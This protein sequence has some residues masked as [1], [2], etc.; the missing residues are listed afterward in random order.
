MQSSHNAKI[1]L[2]IPHLGGGGAERVIEILACNLSAQK[3]ELHLGLVTQ[4]Q[5][6][7]KNLPFSLTIHPLGA[8]RVRAGAIPLLKLVRQLKPDLILSGIF[9]L[10]FLVLLLRPLFPQQTRILIR[11]N[12]TVSAA[13]AFGGLPSTTRILYQLLYRCADRIICQTQAMADDL[14]A[15]L[16]LA[17]NR[18]AVLP[19]PVNVEEIR[20]AARRN[21]VLWTGPGP[22]L[23]AIGR[24]SPEKGFDLLLSAFSIIHEQY[25]SADLVIAGSGPQESALKVQS[26]ALALDAAVYFTG[27]IPDPVSY[28]PGATLFVLSSRH[29]GLPNALLE[30][31]AGELPIVALPASAG[32]VE[33]LRD[34]PGIWLAPR[35]SAEAL[36][37][38]L[39]AALKSL[40]SGERFPHRFVKQFRLDSAIAAYE[41]LI[42]L[43]LDRPSL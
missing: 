10:N 29:E 6:C 24:L 26:S 20:S 13:L 12:A 34:Q 5:I 14:T 38:S 41:N 9:H 15:Q 2:L 1:L 22:H 33:L 17:A 30:S 43:A 42:D 8:S 7:T 32:L 35:I 40:N 27:S 4:T 37:A 36:A 25:P 11:Q 39:L 3:Y 16:H 19:N 18:L 31:A 23:L 21:P 28:F